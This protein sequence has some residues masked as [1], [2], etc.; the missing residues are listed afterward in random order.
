MHIWLVHLLDY[1]SV[2]CGRF[3]KCVIN[4]LRG[5]ACL[6]MIL[7]VDGTTYGICIYMQSDWLLEFA[8]D[9][10]EM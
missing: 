4:R 9:V 6:T 1:L 2:K 3:L 10:S 8:C 5:A 7:N